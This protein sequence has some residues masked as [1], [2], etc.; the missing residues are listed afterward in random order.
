MDGLLD[1]GLEGFVFGFDANHIFWCPFVFDFL[2]NKRIITTYY[3]L[4]KLIIASC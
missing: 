2:T 1:F 3:D 4:Y